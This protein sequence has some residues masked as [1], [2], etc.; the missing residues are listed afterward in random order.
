MRIEVIAGPDAGWGVELPPGR[1]LVGRALHCSIV[2]DDPAVEA[3]HLVLDI[4]DTG[5][6]NVVQLAGR[7]PIVVATDRLEFGDSRLRLASNSVSR[8]RGP[9]LV[10]GVTVEM[11]LGS[12]G[13]APVLLDVDRLTMVDDHLDLARGQAIVRSL[14]SQAAAQG[15]TAPGCLLTGPGDPALDA[16]ESVLELGARWRARWTTHDQSVRLH[17]AGAIPRHNEGPGQVFMNSEAWRSA[18]LQPSSVRTNRSA[19][20]PTV[21]RGLGTTPNVASGS[22]ERVPATISTVVVA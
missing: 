11:P 1:H 12:A 18:I 17:A 14:F 20:S 15:L 5:L 2:I 6:I 4:G 9:G 19:N 7:V 3:N 16:C 10:L 22:S 13:G 8:D 21:W